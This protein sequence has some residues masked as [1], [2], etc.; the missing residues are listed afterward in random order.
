MGALHLPW[1]EP[2]ATLGRE[3]GSRMA[4]PGELTQLKPIVKGDRA[5]D[6]LAYLPLS[7]PLAT[8]GEPGPRR[9]KWLAG[10]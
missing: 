6:K 8:S 1:A 3:R 7:E 9:R 4:L 5:L 2:F 10:L